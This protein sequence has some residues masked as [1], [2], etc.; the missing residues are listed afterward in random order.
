METYVRAVIFSCTLKPQIGVLMIY[1]IQTS[2]P[3]RNMPRPSETISRSCDTSF[4][5]L[6]RDLADV[7]TLVHESNSCKY[8]IYKL[9]FSNYRTN[10][11]DFLLTLHAR[12]EPNE[13]IPVRFSFSFVQSEID[14]GCSHQ[15]VP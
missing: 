7:I 2:V 6:T 13:N 1:K 11:T 4:P 12:N 5:M 14:E 8:E 15:I 9:I 3:S 10:L